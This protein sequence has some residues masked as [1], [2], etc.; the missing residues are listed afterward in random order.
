[1]RI[2]ENELKLSVPISIAFTWFKNLDKKATTAFD[3][4]ANHSQVG[5]TG[6]LF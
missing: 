6:M 5:R 3:L 1:V 2:L 4:I